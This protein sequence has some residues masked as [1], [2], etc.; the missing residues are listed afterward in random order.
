VSGPKIEHSRKIGVWL[1]LIAALGVAVGGYI[2]MQEQ[3]AASGE[4]DA[5]SPSSGAPGAPPPNH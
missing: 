3:E 1:G 2:G 4:G 5:A